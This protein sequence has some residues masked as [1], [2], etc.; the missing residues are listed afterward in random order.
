LICKYL[1]T[2][3]D[4]FEHNPELKMEE[5]NQILEFQLQLMWLELVYSNAL[6]RSKFIAFQMVK[7]KCSKTQVEQKI[8]R[9]KI[10]RNKD[11]MEMIYLAYKRRSFIKVERV[12]MKIYYRQYHPAFQKIKR[13]RVIPMRLIHTL[14]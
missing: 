9:R 14:K 12:L 10:K 8:V 7:K 11:D 6:M 5:K 4:D 2:T 1:G 13:A 3:V